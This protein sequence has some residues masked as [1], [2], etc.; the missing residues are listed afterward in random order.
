MSDKNPPIDIVMLGAGASMAA[1]FPPAA[2]LSAH[3]EAAFQALGSLPVSSNMIDMIAD[4]IQWLRDIQKRLTPI[5]EK[6]SGLDTANI[7][8]VFRI[9]G[10]EV[11][12]SSPPPNAADTLI[13]GYQYPR[14]IRMMAIAL[15]H[16]PRFPSIKDFDD[17]SVY[18]WL[19]SH[20]VRTSGTNG[21]REVVVVSTNYDLVLEF[22]AG[23]NPAIDLSYTYSRDS[24]LQHLFQRQGTAECT[25]RYLKLHGSVNWWGPKAGSRASS[26]S[27]RSMVECESPLAAVAERYD[28]A[29]RDIEM[30]PPGALKDIIYRRNWTEV[31]EQ[32]YADFCRCRKLTIVGYSFSPG[33]VL[34]QQ[35]ATLGLARSPFLNTIAV[36]DPNANDVVATLRGYFRDSFN[37]RV[38]WV[39]LPKRFDDETPNWAPSEIF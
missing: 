36:V 12:S 5:S 30:V 22:A 13:P 25:L 14:L 39:V 24:D 21:K 27:A 17:S 9:W 4:D 26:Q 33:D 35:M 16:S 2:G 8:D 28:S 15:A 18:S 29:G 32:A 10:H 23:R 11:Q 37:S 31:W 34:V 6:L 19:V 1:G 3:L 7:E 20:L 38:E